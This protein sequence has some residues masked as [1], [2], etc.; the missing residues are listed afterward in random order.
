MNNGNLQCEDGNI[1]TSNKHIPETSSTMTWWL[2]SDPAGWYQRI[3]S[4]VPYFDLI[5]FCTVTW[6]VYL[7][8][9]SAIYSSLMFTTK[10]SWVSLIFT[11]QYILE[12]ICNK[13]NKWRGGSL[14]EVYKVMWNS[15]DHIHHPCYLA[16]RYVCDSR[17][18]KKFLT[19]LNR[20]HTA[21]N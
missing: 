5:I 19:W 10:I 4:I 20:R 13:H 12:I 16:E 17:Q 9:S 3:V 14:S 18:K 8:S 7:W 1:K 2:S 6:R 15:K 21:I 11:A